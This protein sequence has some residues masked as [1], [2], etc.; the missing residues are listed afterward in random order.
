M[1]EFRRDL[2]RLEEHLL[3]VKTRLA[4]VE[5]NLFKTRSAYESRLDALEQA[6]IEMTAILRQMGEAMS[7]DKEKEQSEAH[8]S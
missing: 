1:S 6:V 3:R 2:D 4:D 8:G 5:R 7:P